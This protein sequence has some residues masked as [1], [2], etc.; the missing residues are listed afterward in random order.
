MEGVLAWSTLILRLE[1]FHNY[2]RHE[3]TVGHALDVPAPEE[4]H[5]APRRAKGA[6]VKRHF[7]ESRPRM[8]VQRSLVGA[9]D[10][11]AGRDERVRCDVMALRLHLFATRPF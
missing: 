6:I 11:S 5:P 8:F 3:R 2:L 10:G 9:M 7:F 4:G 1:T